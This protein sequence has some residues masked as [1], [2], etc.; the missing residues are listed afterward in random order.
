MEVTA[1]ELERT[2]HSHLGRVVCIGWFNVS[3]TDAAQQPQAQGLITPAALQDSMCSS[4]LTLPAQG[5]GWQMTEG[6]L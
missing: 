4:H 5:G 3:L 1:H 6:T 2:S